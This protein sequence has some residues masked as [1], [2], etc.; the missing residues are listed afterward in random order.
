MTDLSPIPVCT[1]HPDVSEGVRRCTRC[2]RNFCSDCIVMIGG[3]PYCA[4]CKGE[5]LLD[6]RSG[7]DGSLPFASLG[8]RFAALFLDLI[9]WTAL[10]YYLVFSAAFRGRTIGMDWKVIAAS[11]SFVIYEGLML[12]LRGQTLGK[13]ALKTKVVRVDGTP[14]TSG[15]A[16]LRAFIRWI[17]SFLYI[18]DWISIFFTRER[19]CVHDMVAKTRVVNTD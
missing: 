19:L 12:Q 18:I 9:P 17:L 6:V 11:F 4:S 13:M 8:R 2:A 14:I 1:N 10:Q 7:I 16:W 15:Q 5:Q 3:Q